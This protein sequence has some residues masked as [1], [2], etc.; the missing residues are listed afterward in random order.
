MLDRFGI[1]VDVRRA[2]EY[3]FILK[4]KVAISDGLIHWLLTWGGNV[5]VMLPEFLN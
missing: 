3:S 1:D 2:D 4:A 5:R